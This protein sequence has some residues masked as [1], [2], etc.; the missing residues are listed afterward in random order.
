MPIINDADREAIRVMREE[1]IE[2]EKW[3]ANCPFTLSEDYATACDRA[4]E[5]RKRL[6]LPEVQ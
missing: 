4:I 5:L 2:L 3:M 1:L 6:G